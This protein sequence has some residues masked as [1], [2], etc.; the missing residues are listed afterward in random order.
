M[1]TTW[2]N[3][4]KP[5]KILLKLRPPKLSAAQVEML[6]ALR[7]GS[8]LKSHRYLDGLKIYQLHTLDGAVKAVDPGVVEA[9]QAQGLIYS[10]QKFPAATYSLTEQGREPAVWPEK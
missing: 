3:S 2:G 1:F 6:Y 9:L 7:N 5:Q 8:T 10:N 4:I